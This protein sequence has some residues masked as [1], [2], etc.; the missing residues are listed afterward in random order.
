MENSGLNGFSNKSFWIYL[1][2]WLLLSVA[3]NMTSVVTFYVAYDLTDSAAAL[4]DIA[5]MRS[6]WWP[7]VT[8]LFVIGGSLADRLNRRHLLLIVHALVLLPLGF[9]AV[10]AHTGTL[11]VGQVTVLLPAIDGVSAVGA[12]A[13]W[14]LVVDLVRQDA[15][16]RAIALISA[17]SMAARII[18]PAVGGVTIGVSDV[19]G[20]YALSAVLAAA[21]FLAVVFVR[22]RHDLP[23]E[24]GLGPQSGQGMYLGA[25]VVLLALGVVYSWT[26]ASPLP[27][28]VRGTGMG[29]TP[30]GFIFFSVGIGGLL[31]PT[32]MYLG[33][34]N[35]AR[36]IRYSTLLF[37]AAAGALGRASLLLAQPTVGSLIAGGIVGSAIVGGTRI[38][39]YTAAL[40]F[41]PPVRRGLSIGIVLAI[42][43]TAA[44][45]SPLLSRIRI[46]P[47]VLLLAAG[48]VLAGVFFTAGLL[49]SRQRPAAV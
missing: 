42:A 43:Y 40:T 11:A 18:G 37:M 39:A 2:G 19:G 12:A 36:L 9:A 33:I 7:L 4:G 31:A 15:V 14:V 46:D 47:S 17:P 13:R 5:F 22:P 10:A 8:A 25:L 48:M 20:A 45:L 44:S 35:I 24:A 49:R 23:G 1:G 34:R 6:S 16:F 41:V 32:G 21:F 30:L 3:T 26:F 28:I 27:G 29:P 38:A